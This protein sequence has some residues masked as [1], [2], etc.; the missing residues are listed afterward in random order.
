M[1]RGINPPNGSVLAPLDFSGAESFA[2]F[3]GTTSVLG[4]NGEMVDVSDG[5]ITATGSSVELFD[6]W[7]RGSTF[8]LFGLPADRLAPGDLYQLF[9][10]AQPAGSIHSARGV[11]SYIHTLTNQ[12]VSLGPIPPVP[13][14]RTLSTTSP[15]RFEVTVGRQD[16][17]RGTLLLVFTQGAAA[18]DREL[19]LYMTADYLGGAPSSWDVSTPDLSA[20]G[21][22][23]NLGLFA[24]VATGWSVM[25]TSATSLVA[26]LGE[27]YGGPTSFSFGVQTSG[28]TPLTANRSRVVKRMLRPWPLKF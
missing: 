26:I 13:S 17:Y 27:P 1:R 23:A 7:Y 12:T 2:P 19:R 14:V 24:N 3:V 6:A 5:L 11:M 25:P 10:S 4:L 9:V 18:G 21:Y 28:N 15:P 16:A 20:A 22:D 8:G